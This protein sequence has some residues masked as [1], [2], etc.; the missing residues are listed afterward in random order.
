[1]AGRHPSP[2]K[3]TPPMMTAKMPPQ[4]PSYAPSEFVEN[5]SPY[6]AGLKFNQ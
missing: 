3:L 1:M 6:D 5:C 4:S 2:V